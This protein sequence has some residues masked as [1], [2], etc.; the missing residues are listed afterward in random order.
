MI[1][2]VLVLFCVFLL[3]MILHV[4]FRLQQHQRVSQLANLRR[5]LMNLVYKEAIDVKSELFKFVYT[6]L[7]VLIRIH[8]FNLRDRL[9][10][11]KQAVEIVLRKDE[12]SQKRDLISKELTE[13]LYG[14][15]GKE[16]KQFFSAFSSIIYRTIMKNHFLFVLHL[17]SLVVFFFV[18]LM[19]FHSLGW[20]MNLQKAIKDIGKLNQQFTGGRSRRFASV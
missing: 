16:V 3:V 8:F 10:T 4:R 12:Y 19:H 17:I 7:E 9:L 2:I 5:E 14:E 13:A 11:S 15:N 6:C 1:I 20:I 18:R